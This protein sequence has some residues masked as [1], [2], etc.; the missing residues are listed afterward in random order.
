MDWFLYDRDLRQ[1]VVNMNT[2]M[3]DFSFLID[4]SKYL[5]QSL[6]HIQIQYHPWLRHTESS[7]QS[8]NNSMAAVKLFKG[9]S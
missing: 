8:T 2:A 3:E 7:H 1:V 9:F 6:L 5:H 4:L